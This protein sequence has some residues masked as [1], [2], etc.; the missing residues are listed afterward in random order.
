MYKKIIKMNIVFFIV[1]SIV[2]VCS[3]E[4]YALLI[5][6]KSFLHQDT[7]KES[8]EGDTASSYKDKT[9]DATGQVSEA[10]EDIH[11]LPPVVSVEKHVTESAISAHNE[12]TAT[13][14]TY[15]P[16]EYDRI[17]TI[18]NL[19]VD[20]DPSLV[21]RKGRTIGVA[22]PYDFDSSFSLGEGI[23]FDGIKLIVQTITKNEAIIN[24]KK[25]EN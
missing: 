11:G 24:R 18:G 15:V 7:T 25:E 4:T 2:L 12:V 16:N 6:E 10:T 1:L 8:P 21:L 5:H 22:L 23:K 14:A 13:I 9:I 3:M 19:P 20:H 17:V